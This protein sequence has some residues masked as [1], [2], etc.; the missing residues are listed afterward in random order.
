MNELYNASHTMRLQTLVVAL[1]AVVVGI[2]CASQPEPKPNRNLDRASR[3]R[4]R[5]GSGH[6]AT[7]DQSM[8]MEMS[9]GVLD[10]HVVDRSI[11]PHERAMGRC[12]DKAGDARKYLSGQVVMRFFVGATG[13]VTSVNVV[14][15]ALGSYP[16]ERCLI[17]EAMRIAF[18]APEGRKGT[19]FEYSLN[20]QSTGERSVVPY[21]GVDMARHV[22]E[23]SSDISNCGQLAAEDVDVITYV[24]PGG[25]VGSVGFVSQSAIDPMAATC[26]ATLIRKVRVSDAP[27]ARSSVVLRAT[28]PIAMAFERFAGDPRRNAKPSGRRR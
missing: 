27:A 13:Q 18:P 10:E 9:I 23:V 12:F 28:F 20:F 2:G 5:L 22:S 16:V 8:N 24:E 6:V 1:L 11:K 26:V 17:G 19:D 21:S 15:N 3:S 14:Q 4:D 7:E 25:S